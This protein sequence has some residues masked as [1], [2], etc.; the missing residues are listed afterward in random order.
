M[1]M[2]KV[3]AKMDNELSLEKRLSA[4]ANPSSV[5]C[6]MAEPMKAFFLAMRRGEMSPQVIER[7]IVPKRAKSKKS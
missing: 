6:E 5:E 7:K 4:I 3:V 1:V 2:I